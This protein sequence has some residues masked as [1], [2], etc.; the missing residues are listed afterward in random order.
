MLTF[1][2]GRYQQYHTRINCFSQHFISVRSKYKLSLLGGE[3]KNA[4]FWHFSCHTAWPPPP[5]PV[6]QHDDC[7]PKGAH[8]FT[9]AMGTA[10]VNFY[11]K[12][13]NYPHTHNKKDGALALFFVFK[14]LPSAWSVIVFPHTTQTL[15]S[16]RIMKFQFCQDFYLWITGRI[17]KEKWRATRHITAC[18]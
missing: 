3:G 10:W 11:R 8:T 1:Y 17:Q 16:R 13:N 4:T 12:C 6:C 2:P 9:S 5:P 14:I 7:R 18:F 15:V